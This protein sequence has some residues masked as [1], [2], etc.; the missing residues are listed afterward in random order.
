MH[1]KGVYL[2]PIRLTASSFQSGFMP[3]EHANPR[4]FETSQILAGFKLE[5]DSPGPTLGTNLEVMRPVR[6][7]EL[8]LDITKRSTIRLHFRANDARQGDRFL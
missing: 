7:D 6:C 8:W 5:I 3:G 4:Q 2:K 1:A